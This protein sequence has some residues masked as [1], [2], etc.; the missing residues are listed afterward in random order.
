MHHR[1]VT[2][3]KVPLATVEAKLAEKGCTVG[4]RWVA[5]DCD[6]TADSVTEITLANVKISVDGMR[7]AMHIDQ[8]D[9]VKNFKPLRVEKV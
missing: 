5:K 8:L 9:F 3:T 7:L 4:S 1:A 6:N 2:D